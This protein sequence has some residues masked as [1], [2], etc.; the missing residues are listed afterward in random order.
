[1]NDGGI[2]SP[3]IVSSQPFVTY[4]GPPGYYSLIMTDPDAPSFFDPVYREF[5]HWVVV[6]ISGNDISSGT[7]IAPYVGAGPP[8]NSGLHRY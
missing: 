8:C 7:V 6:N 1:M 4:T 3:R 2:L 5:I